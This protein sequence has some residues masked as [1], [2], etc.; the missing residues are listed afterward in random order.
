MPG[1]HQRCEYTK[2]FQKHVVRMQ[3]VWPEGQAH[4]VRNSFVMVNTPGGWASKKPWSH[5][6]DHN[7]CVGYLQPQR[8]GCVTNPCKTAQLAIVNN[9]MNTLEIRKQNFGEGV[10]LFVDA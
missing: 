6:A 4:S 10:F 1:N 2:H 7:A 8:Q 5:S 3:H 9:H